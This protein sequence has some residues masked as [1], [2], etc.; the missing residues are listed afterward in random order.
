M[1]ST[2]AVEELRIGIYVQ[3]EGG[4]LSHPF[5]LS[6]FRIVTDEQLRTLRGLGLKHAAPRETVACDLPVRVAS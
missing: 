5:P 4:W 3:L 1:S 2:I 6:G